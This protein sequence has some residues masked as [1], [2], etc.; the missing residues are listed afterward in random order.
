M[1]E[2]RVENIDRSNMV[3]AKLFAGDKGSFGRYVDLVI[4]DAPLWKLLR[5]ELI[6]MLVIPVP[7]ALGIVLRQLFCPMLFGRVGRKPIFGRDIVIRNGDR[8]TLGDNVVIDDHCLLDAR[9]SGTEGIR[10]GDQVI[11]N[12]GATVISKDG[13]IRIGAGSDIGSDVNITSQGGIEIGASVKIAGG[14]KIGGGILAPPPPEGQEGSTTPGETETDD[15]E[16]RRYT[17]GPVRIGDKA[18]LFPDALIL[19]GVVIGE[20]A[21]IGAGAVVSDSVPSASTYAP[22]QRA[23]VL[24]HAPDSAESASDVARALPTSTNRSDPTNQN[25]SSN[26]EGGAL[27]VFYEAVNELNETLAAENRLALSPDTRLMDGGLASIDLVNLV[28]AAETKLEQLGMRVDLVAASGLKPSP[29]RT[30]GTLAAYVDA[31]EADE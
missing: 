9:G 8:I 21:L 17:R 12:R 5:Y 14:C 15:M 28:V 16:Q 24:P 10:I 7:G 20:R 31:A 6:T 13:P 27:G 1:S 29:F 11:L 23:L 25:A 22:R 2:S 4:G 30:L 18:T 3:R 19:D 26:R